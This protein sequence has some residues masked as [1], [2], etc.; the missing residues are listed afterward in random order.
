MLELG[1]RERLMTGTLLAAPLAHNWFVAMGMLDYALASI[2][3]IGCLLLVVRQT[4]APTVAR[5]IGL[6][7]LGVVTWYT[8][9]LAFAVLVMIVMVALLRHRA[10]A[11]A[12]APLAVAF[13]LALASAGIDLA[14]PHTPLALAAAIGRGGSGCEL[15]EVPVVVHEAECPS[16]VTPLVLA[17]SCVPCP[18][19]AEFRS[20]RA[21]RAWCSSRSSS[22]C[23][24]RR[25]V[26]NVSVRVLP[27]LYALALVRAPA[28]P[29]RALRVV[30]ASS[31]V[32]WSLGLG[33]GTVRLA[34]DYAEVAAGTDAVSEGADVL[35]LV[36]D[37]KGSSDNTW[38]LEEVWGL[39]VVAKHTS[40]PLLF[41]HLP[42]HPV[43]YRGTPV[44]DPMRIARDID[45]A[46]SSASRE[47][48]E[49]A[50]ARHA[51]VLEV[52]EPPAGFRLPGKTLVFERGRV[53]IWR[54]VA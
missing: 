7:A 37:R 48:L 31:A 18:W 53:R 2:L 38:A 20:C 21:A 49:R 41:A 10:V 51:W 27:F 36:F 32:A 26:G 16:L 13:V 54:V 34:R 9:V 39:Y 8:Q 42:G 29:S 44:E 19:R 30:L 46:S 35:P 33:Y 28:S 5:A 23:R 40:A 52:G 50:A 3:A 43:G 6:G 45:D 15:G 1:R 14:R 11:R 47:D 22:S 17:A 4:R 12:A 25:S 24:T